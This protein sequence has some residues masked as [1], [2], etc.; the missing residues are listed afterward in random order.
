MSLLSK[1]YSAKYIY[2]IWLAIVI[3]WL[4][5]FIS[6][7]KINSIHFQIPEIQNDIQ[8][9]YISIAEPIKIIA[10]GI[11]RNSSISLWFVM[12]IIWLLV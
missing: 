8:A 12:A 1:R 10:N 9:K 2:Y 7:F 5:P 4:I 11:N 6:N 3:G